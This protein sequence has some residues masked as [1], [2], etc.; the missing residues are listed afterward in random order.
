MLYASETWAPTLYNL[1]RLQDNDRTIISWMCGVITKDQ[2]NS[3][4]ILE[5]IQFDD[6]AQVLRTRRTRWY[7][8]M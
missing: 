3:W 1:H 8:A 7:T 2:V 6:L 4:D 5:R